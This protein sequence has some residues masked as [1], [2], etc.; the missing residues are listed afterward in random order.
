MNW[1][2]KES[3][4]FILN[5]YYHDNC[6]AAKIPELLSETL[7]CLHL[8]LHDFSHQCCLSYGAV[9]TLSA[10]KQVLQQ[11]CP[12]RPSCPTELVPIAY[13][14]LISLSTF[15]NHVVVQRS[16]K[17]QDYHFLWQLILYTRHLE[18]VAPQ[19]PFNFFP[20][21]PLPSSLDSPSLGE[22]TLGIHRIS[23]ALDFINL[24]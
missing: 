15:P 7:K 23:S 10:Q 19:V 8:G 12:R 6:N 1:G 9:G 18:T 5:L 20:I 17:R 21:H 16:F 13:S 4:L 24:Y 2:R 11:I 22:K 14:C 3:T